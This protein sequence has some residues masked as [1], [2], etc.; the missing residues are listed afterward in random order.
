MPCVGKMCSAVMVSSY[1][2][3]IC[4]RSGSLPAK[5]PRFSLRV[6]K[7]RLAVVVCLS[8]E[9]SIRSWIERPGVALPASGSVMLSLLD[10]IHWDCVSCVD[11][12]RS[13]RVL[14]EV[15]LGAQRGRVQSFCREVCDLTE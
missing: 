11:Y 14:I 9:R 8:V 12:E 1:K 15:P 10:S 3:A 13:R 7:E 5:G 6:W 4:L 2:A